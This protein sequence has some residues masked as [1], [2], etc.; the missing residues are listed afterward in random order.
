MGPAQTKW[1]PILKYLAF[2]LMAIGETDIKKCV[3]RWTWISLQK[4]TDSIVDSFQS[5][6]R[7]KASALGKKTVGEVDTFWEHFTHLFLHMKS[8]FL[9]LHPQNPGHRSRKCCCKNFHR[10][11][12]PQTMANCCDT[13]RPC[14]YMALANCDVELSNKMRGFV[15]QSAYGALNG[16]TV[17]LKPHSICSFSCSFTK[18]TWH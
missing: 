16:L 4:A 10:L 7:D 11:S 13:R 1:M 2:S 18:M 15:E 17:Y 3:L 8:P 6:T 9:A 12:L 5:L 14:C